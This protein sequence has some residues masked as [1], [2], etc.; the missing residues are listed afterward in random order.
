MTLIESIVYPEAD[1][2][3]PNYPHAPLGWASADAQ[4]VAAA[5]G[6]AMSATH[7]DVVRALQDYY[8]RH[9][10]SGINVRELHD[11]LDERFHAAG[12]LRAL[13]VL[14]PKGPVAQGCRIAGLPVPPGA[15]DK[16]MG[17]VE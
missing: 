8:A 11:A 5:E 4:K 12:G 3:D 17:S 1:A 10:N 13:Y 9:A 2:V 15:I 16:G 14:F 6:L 7:W